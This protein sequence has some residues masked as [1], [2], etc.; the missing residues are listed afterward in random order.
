MVPFPSIVW[1]GVI[2]G[3]YEQNIF[4]RSG[5]NTSFTSFQFSASGTESGVSSRIIGGEQATAGEWPYMVA[6]TA[7]NSSHV[8]VVV[9]ILVVVMF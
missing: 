6:L 3:I 7:R 8:F 2:R 5:W 4:I 9:V 1:V